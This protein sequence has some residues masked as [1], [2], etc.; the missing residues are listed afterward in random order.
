MSNYPDNDRNPSRG[1]FYVICPDCG[2]EYET[3][4]DTDLG[5]TTADD[6]CPECAWERHCRD[7]GA[8]PATPAVP[9]TVRK[10]IAPG[11]FIHAF[12]DDKRKAT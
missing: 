5:F 7:S 6:D 2:H 11:V 1:T 3:T 10:Y 4:G 9:G 8:I 12:V